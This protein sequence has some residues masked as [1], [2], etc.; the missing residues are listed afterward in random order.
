MPQETNLN[1]APYFDDF[2]AN[3]DYYKVLF[4]PGYPVQARELNNL[5][6]ILQS[7]IENFGQH[8]FKEGAKVIPG[9]TSY[10]STYD[11]VQLVNTYVGIPLSNYLK[12]LVGSTITGES[13][14][15]TAVVEECLLDSESER[16]NT[17][18][19]ISYLSS[20]IDDAQKTFSD[21]ELL[22]SSANIATGRTIIGAG[23]P[24]ASTIPTDATT[25]G[26]AFFIQ[27]GIYFAK[28]NFIQVA[29][30]TMLLDQYGS[31]PSYRIGLLI[32]E[33]V[34]NSDI[35]ETL[36]DN[37]RGF[38][39]Y[40][41][42]GADRLKITASLTKK[43]LTDFND[44]NFIELAVVQAGRLRSKKETTSY[45]HLEDKLASRTYAESGDYYVKPFDLVVKESLNDNVGNRGVF[46]PGQ[47]TYSGSSPAEDLALYK[48]SPG[49]AFVKG[50]DIETLGTTYLDSLKPRSLKILEGQAINYNAGSTFKLNRVFGS[51]EIGI[52]NTFILSLR[53]ARVG[54]A[55]TIAAGSEIGLARVYDFNLDSGS[56]NAAVPDT[57][58]WSLR[59]YDIQTVT[60]ISVNEPITLTVPTHIKGERSGATAFLRSAVT[61]KVSF[62]V[63]DKSG[64]F[65][66]GE[67]FIIDGVANTRVATAVTAY[68]F[69]DV[70]S[71]HA[72]TGSGS[73]V[74]YFS[75]DTI[76]TLGFSVGVSSISGESGGVSTVT[77][78]NTRFPSNI[79][80]GNIV[81]F[82]NGT[83]SDPAFASV[84][85]VASSAIV[86]SGVTTVAGVADGKLPASQTDL[87]AFDVMVTRQDASVDNSFFTEMP[88]ANI[89]EIDLT[90]A[91][92]II[93]RSYSVN[94]ANNQLSSK[95]VAG[96]NETF[97]PFDVERYTLIRSNG[98]TEVLTSDKF[99]LTVG[100]SQLQLYNLGA[101]DTAA[102]LVATLKKVNPKSKVKLKNRVNTLIVDKSTNVA[103][104][105]GTTTI[106]DGLTYGNY[107]FGTRVQDEFIS[108]NTPDIIKIHAIYEVATNPAT[109]N[110][111]P[112][113]PKAVLTS[114]T[115][116]TGKTTDLI[117]GEMLEGE[118]SGAIAMVAEKVNDTTISFIPENKFNF[119]LGETVFFKESNLRAVVSNVQVPSLEVSAN[120]KFNTGQNPSFYDTGFI[121]KREGKKSPQRKLKIY[122]ESGNYQSSD[123]GD[124]TT[125]QSYDTFDYKT[126][127]Q[128]VN[129]VRNTDMIDIRPRTAPYTV[130]E[131]SRSPLEFLGRTFT[132][133]GDS[134]AN[135][136]ASNE[137]I[138]TDFSFYLGRI[139]RVYVNKFGQMQVK[140]GTPSENPQKPAPIQDALEIASITLPPY[141]YDVG[142]A[143]VQFLD[144]K[145]YR[146]V[147]IKKLEGRIKNLEYYTTLSL[148]ETNT[149]N[150]F[151]SDD[152]GLNRFKSG[153]YVDNFTSL[154]AQED[155]VK[156]KN[157]IDAKHKE[158]RPEHFTT[159]VD[160]MPGP[161][162]GVNAQTDKQ[163]AAPQG[164]NIR[165]TGDIVSLDYTE[166]EW[167]SQQFATRTES[168]TPFLISFWQGSIE[169]TPASDTWTDQQR[170]DARVINVEGNFAET[171]QVAS[172]TLD[173]D[174]QTGFAPS[175]WNA[176]ETE[177]TGQEIIDT[178]SERFVSGGGDRTIGSGNGIVNRWQETVTDRV[179]QDNFRE[180]I[181]TGIQ[182]RTGTRTVITE[183]FDETS[184]GDRVVSR[185]LISF[186]RSR[187]IQ[188]N[189]NSVK[190]STRLYPF[191]DG[192]G[193]SKY[194]VPKLLEI[195]M[196]SGTFQVGETVSGVMLPSAQ[197]PVD[198]EGTAAAITFRVA[199]SN[200]RAGPYNS[201]TAV[202]L[203]NPYDRQ[204]LPGTYSS[205]SQVL[206]VDCFS[207]SNE[208]EGTYSGFVAK[209]MRLTGQTSGA[210][211]TV[212]NLRLVS[213]ISANIQ[214]SFFIP[215]PNFA[216]NPRFE[217]GAK[218]FALNNLD[219]NDRMAA[220]SYSEEQFTST[221][222]LETVQETI[223]STRNARTEIQ[224]VS[225]QRDTSRT[226]GT[227]FV[228]TE[229]LS[230]SQR[231]ITVNQRGWV[232]DPLAQSFG[233]D[234]E[235][236]IYLTSCDIYF[237]SVDDGSTPVTFQLRT[238]DNGLPTGRILPFSE[239]VLSPSDI[240]TSAD[241]S[242]ATRFTFKAPVYMEA[243]VEYCM[244]L[245]SNSTKYQVYISRV[246]EVD[247]ITQTFISNQPFLGSLFKSQNASTWEPSQWEDLKFNLY[248]AEFSQLTGSVD[249]F[250]PELSKGNQQ[251]A[252]LQPNPIEFTSR[253]IRVG[254][255]STLEDTALVIGN[256]VTQFGT[257]ASGTFVASAGVATDTLNV[258]N[259]G[260][261]YTPSEDTLLFGSVPLVTITGSGRDAKADVTINN[262]VAVAATITESGSGYV[263][264]DVLG[265]NTIG[266]NSLGLGAQFSVVSIAST[267]ELVLEGVQGDF[268]VAGSG[269]TVTFFN[270][271]TGLTTDLNAAAGGNVQINNLA[272]VSDGVH[273][274]V[275]HKNHG[276]YFNDNRVTIEGVKSDQ[277]ATRLT[278]TLN[279]TSTSP[280]SI[281]SDSGFDT[282]ENVGVGTTN[283]GYLLIGNE[284][285][286]YTSADSNT[287][288]GV[289][290][291]V[292]STTSREYPSGTP[293]FKYETNG[294][295]L[296]RINKTHNLN[297]TTVSNPIT[298]DSYTI[299][300]DQ[301]SSG[302]GRSTGESQPILYF[303][304]TKSAGGN[305]VFATQNIPF[306]LITPMVQHVS[307]P[308]TVLN[309]SLRSITATSQ[310]GNELPY[311]N[312]GFEDVAVNRT[313]YL[314]TPRAIY[315]RI[316]ETTKLTTEAGNKSMHLRVNL[317]STDS[318]ISPMVDLQRVNAVLT[319]NRVNKI[320]TN[321]ATDNRVNS[322]FNDPTAFQYLSKE[323][324][325]ENPATG[326]KILVDAHIN[327]YSDIRA[328][329]AI[330]DSD[331]FNPIYV[332]FPGF[333]NLNS[334]GDV[335]NVA[336]SD[337]LPDTF[338]PP[339]T[340]RGFRSSEIDYREYVF[341]ADNLPSFRNYR[342]KIVMTSTS[343]VYVP[344]ARDLRVIALA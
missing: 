204:T 30:E 93:R 177:W 209:D 310:S 342:I 9:N 338:V 48:I 332:P 15:V 198:D 252:R 21:G 257:N 187:N 180:I 280:I 268:V 96:N 339:N 251:I 92:L 50:Y 38:N 82:S 89:A 125:V 168:V 14:G 35:D 200:H 113:A 250:N 290:R 192:E 5:Q 42:P 246:G 147:D 98:K 34:V 81:R 151:I 123:D 237:A 84:V 284:I 61:D 170:I 333:N 184:Q 138:V 243:G 122:F 232:G 303:A 19:Y 247:L 129:G 318:R 234:D 10:S 174:P 190:P 78:V 55:S 328:F 287:I 2:D 231:R 144:H 24:F 64:D 57:N 20:G 225:E 263:V 274:V 269:S 235:T 188:F 264:G 121:T 58:E 8:F 236:G 43:E 286:S 154:N 33:N 262:G 259:T 207:L 112:S 321:Y 140:Y 294:V 210:Q 220:T 320:I 16:N 331:N 116:A 99:E 277:P 213:D 323:I 31:E 77:S 227:Q 283:A 28:G 162:E 182:T 86:V 54:I 1:V 52:G 4:K 159:S 222:T 90:D 266:N 44:S 152:S 319:S 313:N 153:F 65:L 146:M 119:I 13:S 11:C 221:G 334:R 194:C 326:L 106:N 195:T 185:A 324:D 299:K 91:S 118:E 150:L 97:Q 101:D 199:T 343:Q 143:D 36:T 298:F 272:T 305:S 256:T 238:M 155:N 229:T 63:Y 288:S 105:I 102:T 60:E 245:L 41:A 189:A 340:D 289:T 100:N 104:G 306:E 179:V 253:T 226:T 279:S 137:S 164:S 260:I 244:V 206:N 275:N 3:N 18:L 73:T 23:E 296:R 117:S 26:S 203:I 255:N 22:S 261:G 74:T 315:S 300:L 111:D 337:G 148:L 317:N 59:L 230:T 276:M 141:L 40:A 217:T 186:M 132:Q 70:K 46:E 120:F 285:I 191:F 172:R 29:D 142:T 181:D 39:N 115:G 241:G 80:V 254:I 158:L 128:S 108:L 240:E 37:A 75:G 32:T 136:L 248:R 193:V 208:P 130:S 307:V 160:L 330:G 62:N 145:R 183:Q 233:I 131:N 109:D 166:V 302:V 47:L 114:I 212:S 67:S 223:I 344:R 83:S 176:W 27:N 228:G 171:L 139:D 295:S 95:V 309:A 265:I 224:N 205:T 325:L 278:T 201:P 329:Y 133:S 327:E 157:S 281:E 258:I 49:R 267:S 71:V 197:Q 308:G 126:E 301:G 216:N 211:A 45:K 94:I 165:K 214:G 336:D 56:Y 66:V 239:V 175:I 316:N 169:L 88:R 292:D 107:P 134:A 311:L 72:T 51:P 178:S 293:V 167:L 242:V 291:S 79:S 273:F 173:V 304:T 87:S 202:Y 25:T 69:S 6:S 12:Q 68:G 219:S 163:F 110:S 161:V 7:Q 103:S 335:L 196:L 76:Q 17:T 149:A 297:N 270:G 53:D 271:V 215:D 127:I 135:I 85:S 341:T 156:F 282:F 218:V 312:T 249:L 124:I 314:P 322:V